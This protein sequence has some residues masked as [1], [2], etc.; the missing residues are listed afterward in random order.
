MTKA[1]IASEI[2]R[3][4][5]LEKA[6]VVMVIENMMDVI[7]NSLAE[8]EN[9]YLRGFGTFALKQ[10]AEKLGRNIT[11]NTSVLI[12]AH[13]IPFFKPSPDFKDMVK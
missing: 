8:G 2:S 4:T 6:A 7:K 12:P 5:G 9:V 10:S 3:N 11:K 1:E 13:K